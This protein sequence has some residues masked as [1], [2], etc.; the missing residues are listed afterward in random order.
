MSKKPRDYSIT[1]TLLPARDTSS[2]EISDSNVALGGHN[3]LTLPKLKVTQFTRLLWCDRIES[4]AAGK[5]EYK[6]SYIAEE[7]GITKRWAS[8][9]VSFEIGCGSTTYYVTRVQGLDIFGNK[10]KAEDTQPVSDA[11]HADEEE[12]G[13]LVCSPDSDKES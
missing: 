9:G 12:A 5:R 1:A 6:D 2:N 4:S 3:T 13:S 8:A 10:H 7:G 11:G